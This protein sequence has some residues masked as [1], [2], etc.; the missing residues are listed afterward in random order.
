MGK[1]K[2]KQTM[3]GTH[4]EKQQNRE[5]PKGEENLFVTKGAEVLVF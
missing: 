1:K 2:R 4:K 5:L 3:G